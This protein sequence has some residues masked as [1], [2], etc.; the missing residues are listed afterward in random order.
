MDER[1]PNGLEGGPGW[2]RH[3]AWGLGL[4]GASALAWYGRNRQLPEID[5]THLLY[6]PVVLACLWFG[7]RGFAVAALAAACLATAGVGD[8]ATANDLVRSLILILVGGVV[9]AMKEGQRLAQRDA[10]RHRSRWDRDARTGD[11]LQPLQT[12]EAR[13]SDSGVDT[14]STPDAVVEASRAERE[15]AEEQTLLRTLIENL[16]DAVYVKDRQGRFVLCNRQVLGRK[17]VATVEEIV[18]RTDYD[19][20]PADVAERVHEVEQEIMATGRPMIDHARCIIDPASGETTWNLTTKVPLR[21]DEG[22]IIGLVGIGRDITDR[23]RAEE[24]YRTLVDHSLQGLVVLQ[25]GRVVFANS[26]MSDIS[27]YTVEEIL[28]KSPQDIQDFVHADDR[29]CVWDNHRDRLAGKAPP[30]NYEFQIVRKDGTVRWVELHACRI[31]YRGRP[32]IHAA[33][34]DV[35]ERVRAQ[36][37]L[38]QSEARIHALLD[39]IPDLIF[40]LS[41]DGVF[42]DCRVTNSHV[43]YLPPEQFMGKKA[44]E[45][46]PDSIARPLADAIERALKTR[47]PQTL[48]YRLPLSEGISDQECRLV[49]CGEGEVIAIVRDITERK[50]AEKLSQITHDLVAK[51][52]T[53]DHVRKGARLCLDAAVEASQTDCGGVYLVDAAC[54]EMKILTHC[55]MSGRFEPGVLCVGKGSAQMRLLAQGK[56]MYYGAAERRMPLSPAQRK[57]QLRSYAALPIRDEHTLMG[58][59]VVASG[60]CDVISHRCRSAMETIAAQMGTTMARL[61]AE[62]ALLASERNYREIFNAANEAIFVHDPMTATIV[63]VNRTGLDMFGYSV[64]ELRRM[65]V[66]DLRAERSADSAGTIR[67]WFAGAMEEGP[68]VFEWLCKRKDGRCFWVEANLKQARIGGQDRVL[69][70][71]RDVTERIQAIRAAENHRLE[72]ARAWHANALGEM[73]S[74]LAHELN[75]P[76]CA[77]VNYAGGCRRLARREP[78]DLETLC[79]SIEQIAGQAE[80]AGGIIR[81]IRGLVAKRE[82]HRD[83]LDI[84]DVLDE[85]MRMMDAEMARMGI[86]VVRDLAED[87]PKVRGDAVG[88]QQVTLNLVRNALDAMDG[89][90]SPVQSLTLSTRAVGRGD[91]IE[92]AVADTGRGF[93]TQLTERVFDSFFTTKNEG[94]GIGLSLSRRIVEAHGG[95]LW[96]EANENAGAV[97]RFTLP[98]EGVEHEQRKTHRICGR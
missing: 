57:A 37:A 72:L 47:Q 58:A 54:G 62:E 79:N 41:A 94:L 27:G 74:G 29:Q 25:D 39:A 30:Q 13:S 14:E 70:V 77:I 49:A 23:R 95:R 52:N 22:E 42:L 86:T 59:L 18:G 92:I 61:R 60:R 84:H 55:G 24:A 32:A 56:P 98:A 85:T 63:D 50:Q 64:E 88:I 5:G 76:L 75:Q 51:L 80:R 82:P 71:A 8:A 1:G 36:H 93:S 15:R 66:G 96:A 46:L 67:Q 7:W 97:F 10:D 78:V 34:A 17:G 81:R 90:E 53:V 65:N 11:A 4:A 45:V 21:N 12:A 28:A 33:C 26:A 43:L 87:L 91:G 35:T 83:S 69:A 38:K 3:L 9:A 16:P 68:R 48:E 73:A 20:Y 19:F 2:H 44:T 89:G 40:R 31:E 6:L